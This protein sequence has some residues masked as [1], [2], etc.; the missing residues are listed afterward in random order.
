M[1]TPETKTPALAGTADPSRPATYVTPNG[2]ASHAAQGTRPECQ[3]QLLS[4]A[5]A[6]SQDLAMPRSTQPAKETGG[7][8]IPRRALIAVPLLLVLGVA[9]W[10]ASTNAWQLPWVQPPGPLVASGTLEADEVLVGSEVSG[11]I[12]DL[13]K[14]GDP[15]QA[16]AVMAK[17]D[18]SLIQVQLLQAGVAQRQQLQVM[19][20]RYELHSPISGVVTRVPMHIGEVASPGQTVAAV[21]DLTNL[22]LTAYVLERDLGEVRVGQQVESLPIRFRGEP[23][24]AS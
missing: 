20:E 22:D 4:A 18:D 9:V 1:T 23:F 10:W 21:A 12:L 11:R 14:E 13:V 5:Q 24:A 16:G 6:A 17:L 2:A 15:I 19:A 8:H 7:R 3:F